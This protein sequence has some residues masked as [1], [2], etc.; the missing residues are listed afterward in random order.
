MRVLLAIHALLA[1]G[2]LLVG[3][4]A[5]FGIGV[6]GLLFMGAGMVFA[7][8]AGVA[9]TGSRAGIAVAL[10]VLW[11]LACFSARRIADLPAPS[12][13]PDLAMPAGAIVLAVVALVAVLLDWRALRHAAWF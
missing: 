11:V 1:A 4:V 2:F 8:A 3:L 12:A 5:L 7:V 10:G 13:L 6:T 9:Q